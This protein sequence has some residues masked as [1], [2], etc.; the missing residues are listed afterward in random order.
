MEP[1]DNQKRRRKMQIKLMKDY[2]EFKAG[3]VLECDELTGK[4]LVDGGDAVVDTRSKAEIESEVKSE[5]D[6]KVNIK[7]TNKEEKNMT[8]EFIVGKMFQQL[9]GK[10]VTGMSEGTAA[11]GGNLVITGLA[12]LAPVM[13]AGSVAYS[14]CRDIPIGQGVNAMKVPV[15]KGSQYL[16]ATAP[17][18][19]QRGEGAAST[20]TKLQFDARTL[21]LTKS[22]IYIP[23]TS[24]L[25]EDS[26]TLDKWIRAEMAGKLAGALDGEV[27]V[28]STHGYTGVNGD[29]NYCQA[30]TVSSTPTA[31]ELHALK[32]AIA[33]DL[34]PEWYG[35]KSMID[36]IFGT[37]MSEKNVALQ[38]VNP[39]E[40]T[41]LGAKA[42][43]M[44]QLG[45]TDLIIGD[46]SQYTVIKSPLSDRIQIS[47]DRNFD[48]DE[49]IFK[50]VH[51][52]SGAATRYLQATSDS[53]AIGAFAEKS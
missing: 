9:A 13:L 1:E 51:R 26:K 38:I 30:L 4:E 33:G 42:N 5:F 50:L 3:S 2:K 18:V 37:F 32:T 39:K 29:T 19:E 40:M 20:P 52:G 47:V 17:V 21:T 36:L 44:P 35:S 16:K 7:V 53:K 8:T 27:L 10:A 31:T 43:V 14:K 28:G 22:V 49:I 24:E 11:D 46:F 48:T 6:K 15:S 12:E 25:L 23:V 34:T 45:A 41:I